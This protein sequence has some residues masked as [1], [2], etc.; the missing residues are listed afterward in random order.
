MS[1]CNEKATVLMRGGTNQSDRFTKALDPSYF[2]LMDLDIAD[3]ILFAYNFAQHVHFFDQSNTTPQGDW[4]DFFNLF[5][6]QNTSIPLR[7]SRDYTKLKEHIDSVLEEFKNRGELTSHM[8]LF[9]SFLELLEISKERFNNLTHRHLDFY[10]NEIL[11]VHKKE[12]QPDSVHVVFELAK[13]AVNEAILE[14][15]A[16]NGKVDANNIARHYTLDSELVIN[17][18]KVTQL[19]T[20][21]HDANAK[22]LKISTN[23]KTF[24]GLEAPL[25]E[26]QPFWLPF[27]YPSTEKS[28]TELPDAEVGFA[29]ASPML[30]LAEGTRVVTLKLS[31]QQDADVKFPLDESIQ[32]VFSVYATGKESWLGPFELNSVNEVQETINEG[33]STETTYDVLEFKFTISKEEKA[34]LPF[35][36]SI[37]LEPFQTQFPVAQLKIDV[38]KLEG[39]S[40]IGYEVYNALRQRKLAKIKVHV[41]VKEIRSVYV[42]NDNGVLKASKPFFPFTPQPIK[43]SNFF[44][45]YDE[46][47]AKKWSSIKINF[48]WKDTPDDFAK[49]Y[50]AYVKDIA[51]TRKVDAVNEVI[52]NASFG[53]TAAESLKNGVTEAQVAAAVA[54]DGFVDINGEKINKNTNAIVRTNRYFTSRLEMLDS[55][56]WLP[57]EQDLTL[58]NSKTGG[59]FSCNMNITRSNFASINNPTGP[60][61]LRLNNSLLHDVFPRLYAVALSSTSGTVEIPN[62]PYTPIAENISFEYIAEEEREV[63]SQIFNIETPEIKSQNTQKS[64]QEERIQLFHLTG[65]GIR[66]EHNYLKIAARQLGIKT[67]TETIAIDSFLVSKYCIG[68]EL[69]IGL[70]HTHPKDMVSLLIQVLEGT[71]NTE[72]EGFLFGEEI[73]WDVLCSNRWKSV[74][75]QI[76]ANNT[77]NFLKSGIVQFPIPTEATNDNTAFPS[78]FIWVR[79]SMGKAYNVVCKAIDI[80]AQAGIATF[81][82]QGNELSHLDKGLEAKTIKK[83]VTRIPKVKGVSQPYNSFGGYPKESDDKFYRRISE[84]IRHKKRAVTLW[85]YEHLILQQ[86]P[87]VF[88][89][90]CLNHTKIS[91]VNNRVVPKYTSAGDVTIVAIPDIINKNVFDRFEPRLSKATLN[92]I[93]RYINTLNSYH[94]TAKV[95]NPVYEPVTIKLDVSFYEGLD[96]NFYEKQLND[97]IIRLLSPWANDETQEVV[98]GIELHRSVLVDYIEKLSYVDYIQNIVMT[99]ELTVLKDQE[100][101]EVPLVEKQTKIEESLVSPSTPISILVSAKEHSINPILNSCTETKTK[102]NLVCQ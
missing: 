26:D 13:K 97:D 70:E 82:D 93:E 51:V 69:Y 72:L 35:D 56:N 28:F 30:H 9:I 84:R 41:D 95:I 38:T 92:T 100:N 58:F 89:V 44:V 6:I 68:S 8:T 54:A 90:K 52:L 63:T 47:F 39:E 55:K 2:Q 73:Q 67:A 60:F 18:S 87:Q 64:Y 33:S 79:A 36:S 12:A 53:K 99:Q 20:L 16:L 94:V 81:T 46:A 57:I 88:K 78:G 11:G 65:F 29:I 37:F 1:G 85:D 61:R 98:F 22:E 4:Q 76:V 77:D 102:P 101:S 21:I 59:G 48:D 80:H 10:Y 5:G 19:K 86:F 17:Q 25:P 75:D 15:T 74:Q 43:A 91:I 83:L 66:E 71:E 45:Q 24:D 34:I 27:G 50:K 49:W 31:F 40:K 32:K 3:W 62:P 23:A 42:E 96:A 14:G 7:N